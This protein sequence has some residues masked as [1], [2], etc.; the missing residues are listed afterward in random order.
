MKVISIEFGQVTWIVDISM[1][2]GRMYFPE[3]LQK[4][5]TRYSFV[6]SPNLNEILSQEPNVVFEH[7][8]FGDHVI[9]KFSVH[10]DGF[11]V[12]SQAG[13]DVTDRFLD[14]LMD[15]LKE[16]YEATELDINNS[17]R[18]YDSHL[19]VQLDVDL[20]PRME[21]INFVSSQIEKQRESYGL[22]PL[23]Y[24]ASGF[25]LSADGTASNLAPASF[26]IER[27]A[28]QP[29]KNNLYYSTAPLRTND[30]IKLL[31][32]IEASI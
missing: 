9:K 3:A 1:S 21:F 26:T 13:T 19:V 15:W 5:N 7:G 14:D 24:V 12:N 32:D 4:I 8:K 31:E 22:T 18:V 20:A 30:H 6:R 17:Y 10:T 27:R 16:E 11:L 28:K 29:F 25:M 23:E 2:P